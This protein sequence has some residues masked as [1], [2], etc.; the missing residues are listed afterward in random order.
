[1]KTSTWI[2]TPQRDSFIE[3][4]SGR[5][6]YLLEED[7]HLSEID[8]NDIAHGLSINSRWTGQIEEPYNVAQH[9]MGVAMIAEEL[10]PGTGIYGLMHDS[11]EAIL[12]DV[13]TPAK[14][15]MPEYM[16]IEARLLKTILKHFG[17]KPELP[18]SVHK[19]DRIM[20]MTERDILKPKSRKGWGPAYE[21]AERRPGIV[22][23]MI[24]WNSTWKQSR[25]HF[26][27]A[28]YAYGG[29]S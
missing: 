20:L 17:L 19:A 10:E 22:D 16:A 11:T 23:H 25:A 24:T 6:V 18:E 9:S 12:A 29:K 3:T 8:L 7:Q 2:D 1:M 26:L 15:L 28:F 4:V 13:A 21:D 14:R 27:E 5:Y